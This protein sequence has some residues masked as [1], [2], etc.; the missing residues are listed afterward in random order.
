MVTSSR[1]KIQILWQCN[2][3]Y[4]GWIWWKIQNHTFSEKM[5]FL[6]VALYVP[7][8][9]DQFCIKWLSPKNVIFCPKNALF[10][11]KLQYIQVSNPVQLWCQGIF[12]PMVFCYLNPEGQLGASWGTWWNPPLNIFNLAQN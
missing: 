4:I 3:S 11:Q 10:W 8:V 9:T 1:N 7:L 5:C 12:F 6:K 2:D